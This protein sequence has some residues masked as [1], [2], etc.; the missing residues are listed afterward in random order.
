VAVSIVGW[1]SVGVGA[2]VLALS[3]VGAL[4][5]RIPAAEAR[6]CG[7]TR[8]ALAAQPGVLDRVVALASTA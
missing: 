3:V 5:P 6:A 8:T 2:V 7:A 1:G 4:G